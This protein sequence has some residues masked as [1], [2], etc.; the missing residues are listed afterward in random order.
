MNPCFWGPTQTFLLQVVRAHKHI[1]QLILICLCKIILNANVFIAWELL[2]DQG[3]CKDLFPSTAALITDN[4][5]NLK[6]IVTDKDFTRRVVAKNIDPS[7]T[8]ITSVMTKKPTCVSITDSATESL[9]LMIKNRY[10]HL[11]V[12]DDYGN[13]VGLL[14]IGK[15][16]NDTISKLESQKER[17]DYAVEDALEQVSSLYGASEAH[18]VALQALLTPLLN[19]RASSYTSRTLRTLLTSKPNT[20]VHP[21]MSIFSLNEFIHNKFHSY[22]YL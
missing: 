10:R 11:P 17:S 5:G 20:I 16:L 6:G 8:Q 1:H 4:R 15:C 12:L 19:Q 7:S 13:V 18:V 9:N 3:H 21:G 22:I 2:L 14:D